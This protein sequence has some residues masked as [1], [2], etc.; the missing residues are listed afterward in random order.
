MNKAKGLF[1]TV[2]AACLALLPD[3]AS[4][5]GGGAS[6]I[7]LVS[8]TRKLDGIQ[9]WWG[10]IYN[11]SHTEFTILTCVMIPVVGCVLGFLADFILHAIGLDLSKRELAEH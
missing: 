9:K 8:D 6:L 5:A 2:L 4:A 10:N 1:L 3:L 11:E 7:I